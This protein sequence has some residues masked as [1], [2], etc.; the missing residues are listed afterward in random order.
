MRTEVASRHVHRL[1]NH[2]PVTLVSTAHGGRRN[3]MAAAWV[4]PLD[5]EPAKFIAVIAADTF[6][7]EL[8]LASRECVL[9]APTSAQADLVYAVGTSTGRDADKFDKLGIATSPARTVAAPLVDGCA[10]WI[11]CRLLDE[12]GIDER[13]DLF[14][15]Q[16][17]CAWADDAMFQGGR[18]KFLPGG[19]RTIHHEAGGRFF[20][21]GDTIEALR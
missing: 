6:T 7:R 16:A 8:L 1:L 15:L 11:E 2:G 12:P 18:W 17:T 20:A 21:T 19:P 3:V 4:M 14:V 9:H 5:F 10:A 13:H